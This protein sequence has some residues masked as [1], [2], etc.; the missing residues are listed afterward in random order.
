[1]P[2]VSCEEAWCYERARTGED[3]WSDHWVPDPRPPEDAEEHVC[4]DCGL[5]HV[6]EPC[7]PG[8]PCGTGKEEEEAPMPPSRSN[9]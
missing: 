8:C 7:C 4:E 5:V 2:Y 1:M 3:C 9:P 6:P